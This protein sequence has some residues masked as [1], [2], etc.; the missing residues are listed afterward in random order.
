MIECT[1][2]V[3]D[4]AYN[5]YCMVLPVCVV[6]SSNADMLSHKMVS[7]GAYRVLCREVFI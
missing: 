7:H 3:T 5:V 4:M 2:R 1:H 6:V